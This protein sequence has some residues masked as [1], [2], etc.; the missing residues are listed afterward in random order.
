MS[1]DGRDKG[2]RGPADGT[3]RPKRPRATV[4]LEAEQ[5]VEEVDLPARRPPAPPGSPGAI[6][7]LAAERAAAEQSRT[8]EQ[9]Y[10][11]T[12]EPVPWHKLDYRE[13]MLIAKVNGCSREKAISDSG[14]DEPTGAELF[15][16]LLARGL[17][18]PRA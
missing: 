16:A 18:R 10:D 13:A 9:L 8:S 14:L 1:D 17:I 5:I 2:S 15:D 6:A 12:D 11:L 4:E 3:D 7:S